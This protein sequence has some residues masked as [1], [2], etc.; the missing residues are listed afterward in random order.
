MRTPILSTTLPLLIAATAGGQ[1]CSARD[2]FVN[3]SPRTSTPST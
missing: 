2:D 1:D 3:W